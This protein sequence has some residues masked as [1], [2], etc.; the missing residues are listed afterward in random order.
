MAAETN[1]TCKYWRM[2]L[3]DLSEPWSVE[4]EP[5]PGHPRPS[6]SS[7]QN[8]VQHGIET[9]ILDTTLHTGT[10]IDAPKHM[11]AAGKDVGSLTLDDLH[12]PAV[13][14]DISDQIEA[15]TPITVDMVQNGLKKMGEEFHDRDILILYTG[16]Q[17]RHGARGTDPD[18]D[19]Y[20]L[21][22][23]GPTNELVDWA[24]ERNPRWVALDGPSFEHPLNI[25]LRKLRPDV[26][27][28]WERD[29]DWSADGLFPADK[30]F[31]AHHACGEAN[32][33]HVD[34]LGGDVATIKGC[35]VDV[36]CFPWRF[37]GGEAAFA[38]IVAFVRD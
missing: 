10:H 16:W 14:V 2:R 35:R 38:R 37:M 13:I 22:H 23:P 25:Y 11:S 32:V 8:F 9:S 30:W 18:S 12:G 7:L 4:T 5:Y 6:L 19:S 17:E 34:G 3:V 26:V 29:N 20:F 27:E 33:P 36:G 1:A 31:Y 28:K 15:L 21:L 24:L